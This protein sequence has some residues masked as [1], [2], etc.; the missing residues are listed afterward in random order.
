MGALFGG[1]FGAILRWLLGKFFGTKP[2]ADPAAEAARA[3][4]ELSQEEAASDLQAKAANARANAA[5]RVVRG[6]AGKSDADAN[7]ELKR[8]F[9]GAFRD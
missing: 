5:D 3:E 9:P 6:I 8:E 2:K 7:A 4:T 1:I